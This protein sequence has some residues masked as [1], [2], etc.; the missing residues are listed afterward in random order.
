MG[1]GNRVA[2]AWGKHK[3]K[4]NAKKP[5]KAGKKSLE[6]AGPIPKLISALKKEA[7]FA[8]VLHQQ[9]MGALHQMQAKNPSLGQA[10]QKAH[11]Y[12]VFP[13]VGKATLL[14]G[15]A[16]GT[17]EVFEHGRVIGYAGV[18]Q[19]TVGVQVG[20]QTYRELVLFETKQALQSFKQSKVVFAANASAVLVTAGAGKNR[21]PPGMRVFVQSEGGM[22][23]EAGLGAQKFIFKPAALGRLGTTAGLAKAA[24]SQGRKQEAPPAEA[25]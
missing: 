1:I 8:P 18:V 2:V 6:G 22:M 12:A 16:F 7:S 13:D 5:L 3:L 19:V 10:L 20:G 14:L 11:G 23:L 17:G 9:V 15:G 4:K 24:A 25:H 21:G